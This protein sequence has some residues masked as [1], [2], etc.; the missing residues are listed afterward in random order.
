MKKEKTMKIVNK[1][2]KQN[3]KFINEKNDLTNKKFMGIMPNLY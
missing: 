2:Q 1:K 3:H